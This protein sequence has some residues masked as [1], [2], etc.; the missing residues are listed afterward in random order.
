MPPSDDNTQVITTSES[1]SSNSCSPQS[2]NNDCTAAVIPNDSS[3]LAKSPDDESPSVFGNG[4]I[5]S[6]E[7]KVVEASEDTI[8]EKEEEENDQPQD[9]EQAMTT[10]EKECSED[11]PKEIAESQN[12]EVSEEEKKEDSSKNSESKISTQQS[13]E[14]DDIEWLSPFAMPRVKEG[15][16]GENNTTENEEN[17]AKGEKV[18]VLKTLKKGAVAAVGGTMVGVGLVMI[19]LPTP[20]GAVVAS[21]GLAVL[22]SEFDEAKELNDRLIDG[23]KGHLNK[24]RDSIVKGIEKMN[25][26]DINASTSSSSSTSEQ[27][28]EIVEA[29]PVIKV[30]AAA[31]FGSDNNTDAI[32]EEESENSD[33]GGSRSESPPVW[34]HMNAIERARQEKLAKEKYRREH[35][36]HYAQAKEAVTK[37]TGK[38]LSRTLLPLIK[39]T[40]KTEPAVVDGQA[41]DIDSSITDGKSNEDTANSSVTEERENSNTNENQTST[42]TE[43]KGE[44]SRRIE[45]SDNDSEG[46]VVVS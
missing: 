21:S 43:K 37:R 29:G 3:P 25:P 1:G 41:T 38:F 6:E 4:L 19:P 44:E 24:A 16:D 5:E 30:N 14:D 46:Y 42:E 18:G 12:E 10:Q 32:V 40:E 33:G 15:E 23:A 34:L 11:D 27:E 7:E 45:T 20:F 35:Q 39:K 31:S 9:L 2:T 17:D 13:P 22:G 36:T 8:S 28:K 26:D